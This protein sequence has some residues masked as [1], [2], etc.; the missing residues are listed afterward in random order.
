MIR[1]RI[2]ISL[3]LFFVFSWFLIFARPMEFKDIF[4]F[5]SI[6]S[7]KISPDGKKLLFIL[8]Q[9]S[10]EK[11]KR[12]KFLYLFWPEE[13]RSLLLADGLDD[14]SHPA[15]SP[16]GRIITF[17]GKKK[18][19]NEL[20]YFPQRGNARKLFCFDESIVSYEWFADGR[21]IIFT[22][23]KPDPEKKK[24]KEKGFD[25]IIMDEAPLHLL[26][27]WKFDEK[28]IKELSTDGLS[29]RDFE[30][31]PDGEKIALIL[32]RTPLVNDMVNS[33]IYILSIR[34][35]KLEKLTK[36][37]II[38]RNL[39]WGKEGKYIYFLS[40]ANERLEPYYQTSIFKLDSE[41]GE[42]NDL[43]PGFKYEV[44]EYFVSKADGK[45][46]FTAN[47]GV[48]VN[49]YKM[50]PDGSD[51][52]R[53]SNLEGW[54]R[55][56]E[57][58]IKFNKIYCVYSNPDLPFELH[59]FDINNHNL[60]KL[61]NENKWAEEIDTGKC[62]TFR[63][64]SKD[65][66]IVEGLVFYP[67]NFNPSKKYPLLIQI[68]GGPESSYRKYFSTSW[69]TYTYFWTGK[70][71]VV[72]QPNYRGST[73]YGDDVMRSIIG[74]YF[75]KDVD[76]IITGIKAL[77]R[78]GW[79][80]KKAVMGWSAG[81]HLTN[82][83]ITHFNIFSVASSGAGM[84][85]WFSFYA[86]TDMRFIREIWHKGPPYERSSYYLKK[87]PIFYVKNAKTPTIIFCGEKDERVPLPQSREM[88][89]GL[90]WRGVPTKLIV[91]PGEPHGLR[92]PAHQLFKMEEEYK[93]ISKWINKN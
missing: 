91:F 69:G 88:Y 44:H 3:L 27:M 89:Y 57:D 52:M 47:E 72:F 56:I 70:G 45:I 7:I 58:S 12:E 25:A 46:Y 61:T 65:G 11:N 64:K 6:S 19:K 16:N 86:Q 33:E 5:R 87:S 76:D 39:Q 14:I 9:S 24:R 30:I 73:G 90:K 29:V 43:L 1:K 79:V 66:K 8:S 20:Y 71:F 59:S 21:G 50:N 31:S 78:K 26:W 10:L 77:E 51:L 34:D 85:N 2:F 36:N 28:S 74:H 38:E 54:V 23:E 4:K 18:E 40:D 42:I 83:L 60:T 84:S 15:W 81:G 32:S 35:N 49:I 93:W 75:E 62:E 13:R 53:L 82:W 67:E 80:A 92:K 68:H 22:A 48:K 17:L 37:N 63:W 55:H 41:T